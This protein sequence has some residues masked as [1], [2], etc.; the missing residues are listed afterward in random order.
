VSP[1]RKRAAV[2]ELRGVFRVSERRACGL[3]G[4]PRSTQRYR[5]SARDEDVRICRRLRELVRRR[6]RWGYRRLT[7][8]LQQENWRVNA[9]R[10][11]R[12]CRL[13]GL[14]VMPKRRRRRAL[15][16]SSHAC[17]V[18]RAE[19]PRD[20]WSWDFAF[21]RTASGTTL[22]WLSVID[23]YT[24]ECL[25]LKV[26]RNLTSEEVIETLTELFAMYG[27]PRRLRSDN[28]SEFVARSVREWLNRLGIEVSYVEPG[29]PWQNGYVESFHSKLRDEFLSREVFENVAAARRQTAAWRD[30]YNHQRPH[31]SLGYQTPSEFAA[32]WCAASAPAAP[33]LQRHTTGLPQTQLS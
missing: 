6:P 32:R 25:A 14:K 28:G 16:S 26:G 21:D 33:T 31:G 4:Q 24:R 8:M 13:E 20:V 5:G 15:G 12:L 9:K 29:S 1:A 2:K 22:K 10:V 19:R 11:A 17:H 3:L 30:D 23:E 18:L 27:P 7:A